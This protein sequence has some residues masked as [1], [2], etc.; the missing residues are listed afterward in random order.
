M[1]AKQC[2][3]AAEAPVEPSPSLATTA[4]GDKCHPLLPQEGPTPVRMG[5]R[6]DMQPWKHSNIQVT[7]YCT[8]SRRNESSE[9]YF[10]RTIFKSLCIPYFVWLA[11]ISKYKVQSITIIF[12]IKFQENEM[13][14]R[15]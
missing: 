7:F 11:Y 8:G 9:M 15:P 2:L 5:I 13:I 1:K 6:Q 4:Q 10:V 12:S 14:T 3:P